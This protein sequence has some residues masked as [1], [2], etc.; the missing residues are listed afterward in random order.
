MRKKSKD[1]DFFILRKIAQGV[2]ISLVVIA[3]IF[4]YDR[5]LGS[6]ILLYETLPFLSI[7][8]GIDML[9]K[10]GNNNESQSM[11]I[12]R[13]IDEEFNINQDHHIEGI[14]GTNNVI[15]QEETLRAIEDRE[16]ISSDI[17]RRE[18]IQ[19]ITTLEEIRRNFFIEDQTILTDRVF[20]LETALN[21]DFKIDTTAPGPKVL[22][23]H[24][25][26]HEMFIDSDP[27]NLAEGVLGIGARL[28]DELYYT[29]GIESIHHKGI[30]DLSVDGQ[31]F[32][33]AY[34]RMEVSILRIIEE[35]PS[36]EVL[37]DVHRDG[38]NDLSRKYVVDI[39]GR[40]TAKI[41]FFNGLS[42]ILRDGQLVEIGS[43]P[44]PNLSMNLA[45]SFNMQLAANSLYPGFTRRI[46]LR[47][48]RYSLWMMPK[49]LLVEVGAN[50]NTKEEA[51]NAAIP[52]A[53]VLAS[54]ILD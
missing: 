13:N 31:G 53:R 11:E 19:G 40:P 54:V 26:I 18:Q 47:P 8:S 15:F 9:F 28:K 29:Y 25:H 39:D 12:Y 3:G 48:Y 42:K 16:P 23:F 34:E 37:I 27:S 46:Y 44:N 2:F 30:Y 50:T 33:S 51:F 20:D 4:I 45:F 6:K 14:I 35:N 36:I 52:L 24:T 21:A 22:I 1:M 43:L 17:I 10:F 32:S 38:F 49:S 7:D 5:D 41:M